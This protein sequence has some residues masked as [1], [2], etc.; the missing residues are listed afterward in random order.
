MNHAG[1]DEVPDKRSDNAQRRTKPADCR[2]Y[3]PARIEAIYS[4]GKTT[5]DMGS[6]S[7]VAQKNQFP[8][9]AHGPGYC[10]E[11]PRGAW[12]RGGDLGGNGR[13][14]FDHG[15]LDPASKPP[16]PASGLKAS[17]QNCH[18]SPFSAAHRKGAG[19][20]F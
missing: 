13:P 6:K 2:P 20:G 3:S 12:A 14:G 17:G 16:K 11:V 18:K 15:K 1:N 5:P 4:K 10:P 8:E 7:D 9:D 19:E